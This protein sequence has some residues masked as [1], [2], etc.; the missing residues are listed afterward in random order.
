MLIIW[1]KE[2]IYNLLASSQCKI[3]LLVE[4]CDQAKPKVQTTM[5]RKHEDDLALS[6]HSDL[7]IEVDLYREMLEY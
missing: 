4:L 5:R 6:L 7:A 3:C 2:S 1:N